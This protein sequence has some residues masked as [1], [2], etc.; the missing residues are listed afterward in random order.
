[1][2]I[3][4]PMTFFVVRSHSL[5]VGIRSDPPGGKLM[6]RILDCRRIPGIVLAAG[7]VLSLAGPVF[8]AE[9]YRWKSDDGTV[10]YTDDAKR[11]PEHYRKVAKKISTGSLRDYARYTPDRSSTKDSEVALAERLDR[12][13]ATNA[14][15]ES[16]PTAP[17]MQPTQT[18][19]QS[20]SPLVR[21]GPQ[22]E[23]A[24]EVSPGGR[25]NSGPLIVEQ[26]RYRM[27]GGFV[28]RTD[29]VVRQG[30][31]VIAIVKPMPHGL[32]SV[33]TSDIQDERDLEQ[34]H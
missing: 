4:E 10:A 7:F 24:L 32:D 17:H 33:N 22:G 9:L 13:R 6:L 31:E 30:D 1:M 34:R 27:D 20:D 14:A 18:P 29:T 16:H 26:R 11:I 28:T 2:Q 19:S 3:T 15:L 25:E 23:P 8:G 5:L 12:L 21:V